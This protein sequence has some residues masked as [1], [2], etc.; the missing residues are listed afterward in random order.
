M[1]T[2]KISSILSNTWSDVP[3]SS[4]KILNLG[5]PY[6]M[7]LTVNCGSEVNTMIDRNGIPLV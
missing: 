3:R 5:E 2:E 1:G 7:N 6:F 4:G